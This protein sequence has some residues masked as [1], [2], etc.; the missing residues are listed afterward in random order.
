MRKRWI[1]LALALCLM[2]PW[3]LCAGAED[4][5]EAADITKKCS[6]KVSE[7]EKGKFLDGRAGT[8][9]TAKHKNAWVGIKLPKDAEAG[10]LRVEWTF[11]PT[12]YELI[13]YDADM[14]VLRQRTQR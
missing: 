4:S 3:A 13:E 1:A 8:I 10:W 9:W 14:N 2:V 5:G 6:F 12:A 7:G 11:D